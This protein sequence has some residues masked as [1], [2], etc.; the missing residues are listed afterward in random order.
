MGIF[1]PVV[2][3]VLQYPYLARDSDGR[4]YRISAT[5]DFAFS[6]LTMASCSPGG[7]GIFN[8]ASG[9]GPS[10]ATFT[11]VPRSCFSRQV[12][13]YNLTS[14]GIWSATQYGTNDGTCVGPT[15]PNPAHIVQFGLGMFGNTNT[16]PRVFVIL[17]SSASS[18]NHRAYF[19]GVSRLCDVMSG[20][21]ITMANQLTGPGVF[22]IETF[23]VQAFAYGGTATVTLS[24][25]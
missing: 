13:Q 23:K 1:R 24:C 9:S 8:D 20:G 7:L 11:G 10:S 14:S 16:L 21:V 22:S 12:F 3:N 4:A 15:A 6:G 25:P 2:S 17:D 18:A 5:V 19:F